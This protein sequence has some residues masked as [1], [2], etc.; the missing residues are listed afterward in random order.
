MRNITLV[1]ETF[2]LMMKNNWF[3]GPRLL[4]GSL[5]E[6]ILLTLATDICD[7]WC[8]STLK[9]GDKGRCGLRVLGHTAGL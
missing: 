7:K 4:I 6:D 2:G 5:A 3:Q 9:N 1:V 8:L